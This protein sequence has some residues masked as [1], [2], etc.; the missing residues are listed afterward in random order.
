MYFKHQKGSRAVAVIPGI[1]NGHAFIQVITDKDSYYFKSG[2]Y[3][4]KRGGTFRIGDN[5]FSI[6]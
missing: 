3:D 4:Y 5:I 2:L 1:S 6:C